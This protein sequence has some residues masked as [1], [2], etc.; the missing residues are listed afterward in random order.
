M[1]LETLRSARR[2]GQGDLAQRRRLLS[3]LAVPEHAD[4]L[5]RLL[6]QPLMVAAA[7][8]RSMAVQL[9]TEALA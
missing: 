7:R 5:E 1:R 8:E 3:A 9:D 2:W 4:L 6:A